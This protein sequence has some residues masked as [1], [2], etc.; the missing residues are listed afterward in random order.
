MPDLVRNNVYKLYVIKTAKWFSLIMPIIVLFFQENGLS[1]TQIFWLKSAYSIGMLT[2][3]IPSGYFGDVWGRKKTLIV[4]TLLTTAGFSVYSFSFEFWQFL[5]AEFVLGIGQSFIS[6]ADSAMLF[7]SLKSENREK[8]YI[9]YEG[10][11]TSVGNF[12][13]A[14]AGI[15][16]GLLATISLRVP[17]ICQAVVSTLAIPA[18]FT[19]VEPSYSLSKRAAGF[20]DILKVIKLSLHE[21][22]ILRNF[23]FFS[24]LAGTA[25]LTFAWF[26]QPFLID[27]GIPVVLFGLIWTFLNLTVG[28][29]SIFA[30]RIERNF[31][32]KQTSG[33]ITFSIGILFLLTGLFITKWGTI[34]LLVFYI[35]RGIAT[36]VFKD[37]IH[38]MIESE[39]RATV[40]SLRNM[41]IRIIFAIT[42]PILGWITD[43]Y[44]LKSGYLSAGTFFLVA[45]FALYYL[46]YFTKSAQDRQKPVKL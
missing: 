13:E 45:G 7:D 39:Y 29:S 6:G 4:G 22:K 28:T 20:N 17:F 8:E 3:E 19:L 16:G 35:V 30:Y 38:V 14:I 10:R 41:I 42:G 44:S 27:I 9:K 36:P 1:M 43:N 31:S 46:A 26:V 15:L 32:Q 11:V 5:I 18:A 33:L 34:L 24:S 37:Y 12:S 2:M 25:T 40:L 23:M 21:H